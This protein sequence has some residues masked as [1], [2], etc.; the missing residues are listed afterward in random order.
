VKSKYYVSKTKKTPHFE[1][2]IENEK[3]EMEEMCMKVY[4]I[5][6]VKRQRALFVPDSLQ[7]K[8]VI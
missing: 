7:A 5:Y 6:W 2:V 8:L 1:F 4:L 3:Y